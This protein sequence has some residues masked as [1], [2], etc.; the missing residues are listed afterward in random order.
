MTE[1]EE[2]KQIE[3]IELLMLRDPQRG[4]MHMEEPAAKTI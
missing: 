3:I 2:I 1:R 4:E